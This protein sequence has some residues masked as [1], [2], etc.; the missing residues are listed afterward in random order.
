[1]K[2]ILHTK[3]GPPEELELREVDKPIP[4]DNEVLIKMH[5]STV[6]TTDCNVRNRTFVPKMFML[7]AK[8]MFGFKKPKISI[9]GTDLAGV[10]ESTGKNVTKFKVGDKVFGGAGS[11]FGAHA[12]YICV[13]E[14]GV[15]ALI[16]NGMSWEEAAAVYLAAGTALYYIRDL[17]KI[18]R[19]QKILING[20]S[21]A[22][23]TYAVQLAKYYEADVTG[24]CSGVNIDMV[25]SLGANKVIDYTKEDFTKTGEIYDAIFD[26]VGKTTFLECK[27]ILKKNGVYLVNL[28][29]KGE[30]IRMILP[31][32]ANGRKIKGGSAPEKV[33]ILNF[34]KEL[35]EAEKLKPI[36]DR[37]YPLEQV[38]E[39]FRYV[40]M[41]HKKGNVIITIIQNK[42]KVK[43]NENQTFSI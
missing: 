22:I 33:E 9:L 43:N 6:T 12:E 16:P 31:F 35:I 21:G 30:F 19:G 17:G 18:K 20:A 38:A 14:N 8:I 26:V 29:E 15:L 28:I 40:E 25:K 32:M 1:M 27:D 37:S 39:A 13:S 34:L 11:K 24:V 42:D 3:F 23:G 10:V 2:T 4:K 41:G 5:A 7:V 36:I